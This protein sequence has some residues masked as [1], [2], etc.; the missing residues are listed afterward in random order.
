M[1]RKGQVVAPQM[2][3]NLSKDVL[4]KMYKTMSTLNIMDK[5]LYESQR[6]S[7][8]SIQIQIISQEVIF[9]LIKLSGSYIHHLKRLSMYKYHL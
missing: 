7:K 9:S 5:I 3:P 4:V 2:D 8:Y 1:N 6:Y